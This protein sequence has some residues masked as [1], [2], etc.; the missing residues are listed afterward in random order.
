MILFLSG[1][2]VNLFGLEP[3]STILAERDFYLKKYNSV[4]DTMTINTWLNLKRL[5][6][7]LQEVVL[8][9]QIIIDQLLRQNHL[10]SSHWDSI[11][12]M[13]SELKQ[14][15]FANSQIASRSKNDLH[16]MWV[17]KTSASV[18]TILV[19]VMIYL[20]ITSKNKISRY[21]KRQNELESHKIG[22]Q[23]QLLLQELE[24]SKL[25]QREK[26]FRSEL[27][28]GL[29]TYQEKLNLLQKRN[30]LLEEELSKIKNSGNNQE[31]GNFYLPHT[32]IDISEIP[33]DSEGVAAVL[34]AITDERD[35]LMNLAG[36]LQ[37]QIHEEKEKYNKLVLM[38]KALPDE[39]SD[40]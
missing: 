25:K 35:S 20:L 22:I 11:N 6:D 17:L 15:R 26:D 40:S 27:E 34:K 30:S 36:K 1:I 38:I 32:S 23:N 8:R 21:K 24:V 9:D 33:Q 19:L 31:I 39:D 3:D 5:S 2:S 12:S 7:N 14:L 4:K 16:M 10:D 29:I 37:K 28:K 18:L 13:D